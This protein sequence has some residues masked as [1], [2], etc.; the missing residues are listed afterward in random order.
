[1]LIF[2]MTV[3][4]MLRLLT[5]R[6]GRDWPLCK[7]FPNLQCHMSGI[8]AQILD[9]FQS[10]KSLRDKNCMKS[11]SSAPKAFNWLLLKG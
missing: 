1:M 8:V 9:A 11:A 2:I 6:I 10:G 7:V 4:T 3:V 5:T